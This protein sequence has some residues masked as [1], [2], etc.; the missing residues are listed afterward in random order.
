MDIRI[1]RAPSNCA[2][3]ALS[4]PISR[5]PSARAYCSRALRAILPQVYAQLLEAI[6]LGI[7][8][9]PMPE[10]LI[11]LF[12]KA[13]A[14]HLVIASGSQVALLGGL[15]LAPLALLPFGRVRTSYPRPRVVLLC[16]SLPLLGV[17]VALADRGPSMDRALL[18]VLLVALSVFLALS[19]L[20]AR[21]SFRPDRLTL[22]AAAGLVILIVNPAMLFNPGMQLTFAALVGLIT[23][24]PVLMRLCHGIPLVFSLP[25][26]MTVGAQCMTAPVLAWHFGAIPLYAPLTNLFSVPLVGLLLPLGLLTLLCAA[27]Y[28]TGAMALG[29]LLRAVAGCAVAH[30]RMDA[31]AAG[32]SAHLVYAFDAR[33]GTISDNYRDNVLFSVN[34]A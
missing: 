32:W 31:G 15:L 8:G 23:L 21:R 18:M 24:T 22:L 25:P 2:R 5:W 20:A 30:Q 29:D 16:C 1:A 27:I 28:P 13:G 34:L 10:Q 17:Y 11:E 3:S 4:A 7:N 9:S 19:P 12:R 33:R 6:I 14:I 26:A